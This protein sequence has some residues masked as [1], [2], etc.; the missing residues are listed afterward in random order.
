MKFIPEIESVTL[1]GRDHVS[2]FTHRPQS[3][4]EII[5]EVV[6]T[7]SSKEAIIYQNLCWT[8]KQLDDISST[9]AYN[10]QQQFDIQKGDRVFSLLGNIPAFAALTIACL[11]IGAIMVPVNTKLKAQ[12][13]S[14]ILT[15]S[16][17]K[18]VIAEA[19]LTETVE[20]IPLIDA[21][22]LLYLQNIIYIDADAPE[23]GLSSLLEY[24]GEYVV[25]E[26]AETDGAFLCYTS[27]TTGVPKGALISHI[28]IIHTVMH[29][30]YHLGSD[31]HSRTL[32]AVPLFH[33]TGLAAQFL[34]M[35]YVGGATVILRQYQNEEYIRHIVQH[36]VNFV[37]N[38]PTIF[39]M[40]GTSPLLKEQNLDFVKVVGY[41]G[42]PIY[43]QTLEQLKTIFTHAA[44][45]NVY[46]ATETTSPTTVAPADLSM[47]KASAVGFPV[48]NAQVKI[49]DTEGRE[50]GV[51]EVGQLWI[52]GP[53]VIG[54]YW[55]NETANA[56][57]FQDGFWLSGDMAK[58][59]E[60][61]LIYILDRMKDMINR[62][63]EK[64]FSIEVEDVLKGHPNVVEAAV[65]PYPDAIY[66]EK[67]K[68]IIVSNDFNS[69]NIA[70]LQQYC[71]ERLA[72]F[73][74][75]ERFEFVHE[76]PKT[77]S[78]KILKHELKAQFG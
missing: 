21:E 44:F 34:H 16:K 46:G 41:G 14:Y 19:D 4:R 54:E 57:S 1:F 10:L 59:D 12:E 64:I 20:K 13:L 27:G 51:H 9:I 45:H 15:H 70:E 73:K 7:F 69:S 24:Q 32:V 11:K 68:A 31:D 42:S 62:G 18:A 65:I 29:Y 58:R 26:I 28:N 53:M 17:P 77:A 48:K 40:M 30:H 47:A 49:M 50:V 43:R 67:V 66:G 39:L 71:D 36:E 60:E 37:I 76:L 55:D 3:F 33:I 38:V 25:H 6:S 5:E 22:A 72:K 74:I 35:V 63:G 78:G 2:V 56:T 75:P 61:G 23:A 8:Y 52:K